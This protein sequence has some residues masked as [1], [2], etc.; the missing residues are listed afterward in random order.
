MY[1]KPKSFNE[2]RSLFV[3]KVKA[4]NIHRC[5]EYYSII[6]T[7]SI[8][9]RIDPLTEGGDTAQ[10]VGRRGLLNTVGEFSSAHS[11]SL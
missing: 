10:E 7:T 8:T 1:C 5:F 2:R 3:N 6:I 9:I 11:A 4:N